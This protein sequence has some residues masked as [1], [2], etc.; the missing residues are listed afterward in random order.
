MTELS[1]RL[2]G[3]GLIAAVVVIGSS[4]VLGGEIVPPATSR[5]PAPVLLVPGWSDGADELTALRDRFLRSGWPATY[6][7]AVEFDDPT[8]S[9]RAHAEE[10]ARVADALRASTGAQRI[11]V[12]AHSMGGL[13][14]RL[15]IA[16]DGQEVVRRVV[17][18]ASPH[19]GTWT[20]LIAVG[21]GGREMRPGS[22]LLQELAASA[23]A[24]SPSNALTLRSATDLHIVPNSSSTLPGVPD[25]EVCCPTHAGLLDDLPTFRR[26]RTFLL[27]PS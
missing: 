23:Q 22:E 26:I 5:I 16:T 19:L 12:V 1:G 21:E 13:A 18:V 14:T 6:V 25:I 10:L 20:S 3:V 8:G 9:N 2:L 27:D 4:R 11:D 17:F 7:R 24:G 15:W